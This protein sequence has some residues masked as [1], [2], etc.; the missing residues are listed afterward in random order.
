[1]KNPEPICVEFTP[2]NLFRCL[3]NKKCSAV[4][5]SSHTRPRFLAR[6]LQEIGARTIVVEHDYV[7]REYFT[8]YV[9]YY[10][11]CFHDYPRQCKRLHFFSKD[12]NAKLFTAWLGDPGS[13]ELQGG[14]LG[15][16]VARPLPTA[17][18]GRTVVATY[19]PEGRR[20]YT[21]TR[22]YHANLYGYEL[23]VSN[24]LAFQ[25]Q[26]REV[27]ACATVA[28]WTSFQKLNHLYD[29]PAPTPSVVTRSATEYVSAHRQFPSTGLNPQQICNAIRKVGLDPEVFEVTRDLPLSSLIY[30]YVRAQHPVILGLKL[31]NR[32]FHAI[33]VAGYSI[34]EGTNTE[35]AVETEGKLPLY[36]PGLR[37]RKFYAHDDQIGPF[38]SLI[39]KASRKTGRSKPE[40]KCSIHFT[41]NWR[42]EAPEHTVPTPMY[43]VLAIVP[44]SETVRLTFVDAAKWIK[45]L[46]S[47]VKMIHVGEMDHFEWDL[48]LTNVNEYRQSLRTTHAAGEKLA[49]LLQESHP[50]Y[51]WRCLW[52]RATG[53]P[54]LELLMDATEARLGNPFYKAR[55]LDEQLEVYVREVIALPPFD[56]VVRDRIT[57]KLFRL[58]L[59]S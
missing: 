1:M 15:F 24:S 45:R 27:A 34:E 47:V 7:D 58:L 30:A 9:T 35:C 11:K 31:E 37:I 19:P 18:I 59:D 26:D 3:A 39:C 36:M 10:S 12:F 25:E 40:S 17:V 49:R 5:V 29:T 43:P 14:Y 33:T 23:V 32:G 55:W 46:V 50:R 28:L 8:D 2:D 16:V 53:E 6:Y 41:G 44:V 21:A 52:K 42:F 22:P 51:I 38:S 54:I 20:F 13:L 57:E 4:E 56:A 48:H